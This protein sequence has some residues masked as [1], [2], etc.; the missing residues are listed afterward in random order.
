[1]VSL[2]K[3][4]Q[5]PHPQGRSNRNGNGNGTRSCDDP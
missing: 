4:P 1:M 3:L 2:F 5:T